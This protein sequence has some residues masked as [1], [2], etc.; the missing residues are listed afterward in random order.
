VSSR[1]VAEPL[2]QRVKT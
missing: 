2:M 1:H